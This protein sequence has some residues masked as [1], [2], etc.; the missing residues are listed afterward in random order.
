MPLGGCALQHGTHASVSSAEHTCT[1]ARTLTRMRVH[2]CTNRSL[3]KSF[4]FRKR[5]AAG[6]VGRGGRSSRSRNRSAGRALA[7]ARVFEYM[8]GCPAIRPVPDG[9]F[10]RAQ[11]VKKDPLYQQIVSL[12]FTSLS[13]CLYHRLPR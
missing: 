8:H 4:D 7:D 9:A 2:V 10:T 5:K 13:V 12:D 11:W 1:H 3:R 6:K